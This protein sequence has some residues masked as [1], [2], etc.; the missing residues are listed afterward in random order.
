MKLKLENAACFSDLDSV[1]FYLMGVYVLK[2]KCRVSSWYIESMDGEL[3][4]YK[5]II[6]PL[7]EIE[8]IEIDHQSTIH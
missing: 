8:K 5:A 1:E 2:F 3:Y 7:S 4:V 6:Q